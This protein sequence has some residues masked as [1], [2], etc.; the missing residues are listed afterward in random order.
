[1]SLGKMLMKLNPVLPKNWLLVLA[2]V[3]WSGVGIMLLS[4][5]FNWLT[6]PISTITIMLGALGLIISIAANRFEF[7]KLAHKN[8]ER[9]LSFTDKVCLF[10][11]QSWKGYLIIAVMITGGILLRSSAIPK[12]YLAVVYAAIGGALF[13]ASINYYLRFFQVMGSNKSQLEYDV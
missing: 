1:M 8:I 4:Y 10:A 2:G 13:Q 11:F 3:M 9:I 5:A 6:H 12:P 7:S